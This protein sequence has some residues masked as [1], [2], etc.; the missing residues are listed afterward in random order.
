M[1]LQLMAAMRRGDFRLF[2]EGVKP[3]MRL[4]EEY[5]GV[6]L[7]PDLQQ[8]VQQGQ[9]TTQAA[10]QFS[11]ERMDRAMAQTNAARQHQ[12]MQQYQQTTTSQQEQQ[13]LQ[14]LANSVAVT[15]DNWENQIARTDPS[16]AAKSTRC[17]RYDVGS[18]Q[19]TRTAAIR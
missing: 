16:Y 18:G 11:K 12:M 15:V 13:R 10:M 4:C 9:M 7:P 8:Q 19:R 3:Y 2:Y 14:N 17:E 1:G 6:A 5:L